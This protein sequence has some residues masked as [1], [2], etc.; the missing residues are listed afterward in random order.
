MSMARQTRK[1]KMGKMVLDVW[2]HSRVCYTR[3]TTKCSI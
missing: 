3:L 1:K 2:R